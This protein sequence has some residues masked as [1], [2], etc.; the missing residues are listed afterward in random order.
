[1]QPITCD[2][3]TLRDNTQMHHLLGGAVAWIRPGWCKCNFNSASRGQQ[4]AKSRQRMWAWNSSY[5][6]HLVPLGRP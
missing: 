6:S 4:G 5:W 1:M 2:H 3:S